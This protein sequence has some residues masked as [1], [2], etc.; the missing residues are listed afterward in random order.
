VTLSTTLAAALSARVP[1]GMVRYNLRR[2][3]DALADI[4]YD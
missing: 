2:T 1:V 4:W 3:A